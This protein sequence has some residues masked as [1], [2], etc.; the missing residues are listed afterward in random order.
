MKLLAFGFLLIPVSYWVSADQQSP[1][2]EVDEKCV[3]EGRVV[4]ATSGAP[5]SNAQVIL[6]RRGERPFSATTDSKGKF[7]FAKIP[8]GGY[9]LH[10]HREGYVSEMWTD[11]SAE[12][13]GPAFVLQPGQRRDDFVIR[14]TRHGVIFGKIYDADGAPVTDA[15]VYAIEF[16]RIHASS[17]L[18]GHTEKETNDLGEYR[19]FGLQPGRYAVCVRRRIQIEEYSRESDKSAENRKPREIYLPTCFPNTTDSERAAAVTVAAGGEARIDVTPKRGQTFS[20]RGRAR[21]PMNVSPL[22]SVQIWLSSPDSSSVVL[23]ENYVTEARAPEYDFEVRN[24]RPGSYLLKAR[25]EQGKKT[26]EGEQSLEVGTADLEGIVV[27]LTPGAEVIGKVHFTGDEQKS[28]KFARVELDGDKLYGLPGE[29]GEL[30]PD[31]TFRFDNVWTG[32]YRVAFFGQQEPDG[33]AGFYVKSASLGGR[34][35]ERNRFKVVAGT[36]YSDLEVWVARSFAVVE[37]VVSLA[38]RSTYGAAVCLFQDDRAPHS[39]PPN[40]A[41]SDEKGLFRMERALPGKFRLIAFEEEND[42]M[43]LNEAEFSELLE[44]YGKLALI[45]EDTNLRFEIS[46]VPRKSS[47][48]R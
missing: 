40:C 31:G 36:T 3:V 44:K 47:E 14:L 32:D 34:H 5:V 43:L 26:F 45:K 7:T 21:I 1:P 20:V 25:A 11:P 28:L 15:W 39:G 19:I 37:G 33:D 48:K 38:G 17:D 29:M 16:S 22:G 46:P 18:G 6:D 4:D 30:H 10:A 12:K 13:R 27:A 41:Q 8:S 2:L 23:F 42:L 24:V 35:L 9:R